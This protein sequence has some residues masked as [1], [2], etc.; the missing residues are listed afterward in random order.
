MRSIL[1]VATKSNFVKEVEYQNAMLA[2]G[3][4]EIEADYS[5]GERRFRL[6][7]PTRHNGFDHDKSV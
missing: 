4:F 6:G 7:D 1:G 2:S 5:K 3:I